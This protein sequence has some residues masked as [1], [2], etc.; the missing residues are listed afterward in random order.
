MTPEFKLGSLTPEPEFSNIFVYYL[1][2][3]D[4]IVFLIQTRY[5]Q[6]IQLPNAKIV[7]HNKHLKLDI[8]LGISSYNLTSFGL[9]S[10]AT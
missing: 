3:E 9:N 4:N 10:I 5:E 7:F 6:L 8:I 2:Y 1:L